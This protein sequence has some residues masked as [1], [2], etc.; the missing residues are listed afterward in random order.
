MSRW[1]IGLLVIIEL[2][3]VAALE[4]WRPVLLSHWWLR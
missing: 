1:A 2:V 3:G 4:L